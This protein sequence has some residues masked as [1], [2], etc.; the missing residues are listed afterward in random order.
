MH[1]VSLVR[2]V[3]VTPVALPDDDDDLLFW[4]WLASFRY[5]EF[6]EMMEDADDDDQ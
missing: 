1:V 5:E 2:A 4:R 6:L 3:V